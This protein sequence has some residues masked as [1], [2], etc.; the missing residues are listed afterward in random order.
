MASIFLLMFWII[1]HGFILPTPST[2]I[3]LHFHRLERWVIYLCSTKV[4]YRTGKI[5]AFIIS[6]MV[7]NIKKHFSPLDEQSCFIDYIF[8]F[9]CIYEYF[10]KAEGRKKLYS[11]LSYLIYFL[12]T[13]WLANENTGKKENENRG[14]MVLFF[15]VL[16]SSFF[17]HSAVL[18]WANAFYFIILK[19]KGVLRPQCYFLC[20]GFQRL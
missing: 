5:Y 11:L 7:W 18:I 4:L 10:M 17:L 19:W 16:P 1:H 12:S 14:K 9:L 20:E 2:I 15:C 13:S 6:M 3:I 8:F